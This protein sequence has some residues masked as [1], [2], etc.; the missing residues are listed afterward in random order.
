MTLPKMID[1]LVHDISAVTSVC[2]QRMQTIIKKEL[3]YSKSLQDGCQ[4]FRIKAVRD[5]IILQT[6][7]LF[8]SPVVIVTVR[9]TLH[10]SLI[11]I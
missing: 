10:L 2:Y 3:R 6:Y 8:R 9:K 1:E 11:H 5:E 4:K 7:S